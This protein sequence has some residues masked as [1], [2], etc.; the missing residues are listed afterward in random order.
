MRLD[1]LQAKYNTVGI[2]DADVMRKKRITTSK[3]HLNAR[4]ELDEEALLFDIPHFG[5][6]LIPPIML[7]DG[8]NVDDTFHESEPAKTVNIIA[9]LIF[10]QCIVD[11]FCK[12]PNPEGAHRS[13]FLKRSEVQR[14][15]FDES[16]FHTLALDTLFFAFAWRIGTLDDW[17]RCFKWL[18]PEP[19]T[20]IVGKGNQYATCPYFMKWKAFSNRDDLDPEL[21]KAVRKAFWGRFRTYSWV[22]DISQDRIWPTSYRRGFLRWPTNGLKGPRSTAPRLLLKEGS[23]IMFPERLGPE[24]DD[25]IVIDDEDD[26]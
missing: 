10:K 18:F 2:V 8:F 4:I 6:Q 16:P 25:V 22:P 7:G 11:I 5:N 9:T 1:D 21:I 24:D 17:Q 13:S 26:E 3:Q 20:V 14:R 23:V 15:T 19:G 12:S